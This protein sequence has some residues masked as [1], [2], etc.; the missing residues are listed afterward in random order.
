[1]GE[2]VRK[3]E[4]VQH[5]LSL[6]LLFGTVY[7]AAH[8][9]DSHLFQTAPILPCLLYSFIYVHNTVHIQVAHVTKEKFQPW[10]RVLIMNLTILASYLFLTL[11]QR[12]GLVSS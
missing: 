5:V 6:Y 7:L 10:T 1:M 12:Y 4:F 8:F 2:P 9:S 3:R 11:Y